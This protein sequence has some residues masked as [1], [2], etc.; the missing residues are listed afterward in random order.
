MNVAEA[1]G[2]R[3]PCFRLLAYFSSCC[4]LHSLA[5]LSL[6]A[7]YCVTSCNF[8]SGVFFVAIY[9][10]FNGI[11]YFTQYSV[12]LTSGYACQYIL[13]RRAGWGGTSERQM[14]A[15]RP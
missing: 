6:T 10:E 7:L 1:A 9:F 2:S 12:S 5:C 13:S 8:F 3:M 4:G 14:T 11:M 15:S